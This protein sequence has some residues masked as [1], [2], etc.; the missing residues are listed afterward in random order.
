MG[1]L[2]RRDREKR[3]YSLV[4]VTGG[5]SVAAVALLVLA[6]VGVV[7]MGPVLLAVIVAAVAGFLLRG[8][9]RP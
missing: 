6:I 5:A 3:A 8:T 7:G 9:L 2:S 4:L 1:K